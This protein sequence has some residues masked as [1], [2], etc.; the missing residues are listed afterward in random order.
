MA[1]E[2]PK[3]SIVT[4]SYNQ[5]A[6]LEQTMRS[7]LE[8][9]YPRVEYI[10]IDGG[11]TDGSIQIIR[12]YE[13][14]LAYWVSEPDQGPGQ[15]LN[16]GF[17]RAT[18]EIFAWL[19]SDDY[20]LPG[21]L[22]TVARIF[23]TAGVDLVY[24]D[25][26]HVDEHGWV[27]DCSILPSMPP[28]PLLLY[29]VGCLHQE[30]SYWRAALHHQVGEIDET[31]F[32][33]FDVDWFLRL[34][35]VPGCRARYL[36]IPLGVA[37]EH[38]MQNIAQM[39]TGNPEALRMAAGARARFVRVHRIPAWKLALGG[40]YYGAWRRLHETFVRQL[41]WRHL[42]HLPGRNTMRRVLEI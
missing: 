36:R 25:S 6:F 7:V 11:S 21:A 41:G 16:K 19:N 14:Q 2:L 1:N 15:A 8:Q 9:D 24:G 10:I 38:A 18:G 27:T 13:K 28:Q 37:R 23:A 42:L 33:G 12:K 20:I 17:A 3:I 22:R 40:L 29:A 39:R 35:A 26:L 30:S 4:P 34:T 32:P 31:L 5:A